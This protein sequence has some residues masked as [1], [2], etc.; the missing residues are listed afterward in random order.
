M[1]NLSRLPWLLLLLICSCD[2]A[3]KIPTLSPAAAGAQAMADYDTNGDGQLTA[4][5]LD[6]APGLKAALKSIDTDGNGTI[7]KNEIVARVT[8][9]KKDEIALMPFACQVLL[10][11]QPLA[12]AE[13][14][15]T[16]EKLM[17]PEVK[18]A[19]ATTDAGGIAA[20]AIEG[21]QGR[22]MHCGI[23]RVE[24]S[25]KDD[26]GKETLPARYNSQTTLGQEVATD[27][28]GLE[29]TVVIELT[30]R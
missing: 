16:P 10:N 12:G 21:E 28:P 29:R 8:T 13:I 22:V 19:S 23:F 4:A 2:S 30:S 20:L 6:K 11:G 17:G 5:E 3:P 15:M 14:L 18:P 25:K 9:Y 27:V 26:T 24:I 1:Q 7:S